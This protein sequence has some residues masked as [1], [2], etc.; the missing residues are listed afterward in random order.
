M[1]SYLEDKGSYLP[2]TIGSLDILHNGILSFCFNVSFLPFEH[3]LSLFNTCSV[4]STHAPFTSSQKYI[5][6]DP[7]VHTKNVLEKAS[8]WLHCQLFPILVNKISSQFSILSAN[9]CHYFLHYVLYPLYFDVVS[10]DPSLPASKDLLVFYLSLIP[11]FDVFCT[12][13]GNQQVFHL[14]IDSC[15]FALQNH[16]AIKHSIS[17]RQALY[18]QHPHQQSLYLFLNSYNLS[19]SKSFCY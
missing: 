15:D 2:V 14:F 18:F 4:N 11:F 17:E 1:P 7:F 16:I 13:S 9:S 10:D 6:Q 8:I 12:L 3:F 5:D 19:S